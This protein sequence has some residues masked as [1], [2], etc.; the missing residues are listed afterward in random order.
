MEKNT[1]DILSDAIS[2]T[3][4]WQWWHI[5]GDMCQVEFC[6]VLLYDETKPEKASHTSVI[7]IRF[8]GNAFAVLLDNIEDD[9][10]KKWYDRFYD[11]EIRIIPVDTFEFEFD[12]TDYAKNV[13]K[14][15]KNKIRL[16]RFDDFETVFSVKHIL[17]AKCGDVGFIVGGDD[18]EVVGNKGE[19]SEEEIEQAARRW[20][21]YWRD[22][23]RLRKTKDAYDKDYACEIT[24]PADPQVPIGNFYDE[25]EGN[26]N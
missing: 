17:S 24:I 22:Y 6:D 4:C 14:S 16:M 21:E 18:I 23:W 9:S 26:S 5:D 15:Y 8:K 11:D 20:W 25:D 2:E 1:L 13:Y 3:G 10:E 12:N 19:Y 7:A